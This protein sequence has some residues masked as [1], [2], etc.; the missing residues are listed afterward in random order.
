MLTSVYTPCMAR[1]RLNLSRV[2]LVVSL[3]VNLIGLAALGLLCAKVPAVRENLIPLIRQALLGRSVASSSIEDDVQVHGRQIRLTLSEDKATAMVVLPPPPSDRN[4]LVSLETGTEI[5]LDEDSS[6]S[7][8][9]HDG[10]SLEPNIATSYV[11]DPSGN[12]QLF[13]VL[14][15]QRISEAEGRASCGVTR[16]DGWVVIG[17]CTFEVAGDPNACIVSE[18]QRS[19]GQLT[20]RECE[21]IRG[22]FPELPRQRTAEALSEDGIM[23]SLRAV[24]R[25]MCEAGVIHITRQGGALLS[26]VSPSEALRL[27][28]EGEMGVLCG[29]L[30]TLFLYVALGTGVFDVADIREVDLSRYAPIDGVDTNSHAI[31]EVRAGER[32]FAFD[33]TYN[34]VFRGPSGRL[35]AAED[36]RHF[37]RMDRLDDV[38]V[39]RVWDFCDARGAATELDLTDW[40]PHGYNYW[41]QF[42][43]IVYRTLSIPSTN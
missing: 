11:V 1:R 3:S 24:A 31:L 32:W 43:R 6:L 26:V 18:T 33:S 36:L 14:E 41:S 20:P 39:V 10:G 5:L 2:A 19:L 29:G 34:Y 9:L 7:W 17:R 42:N 27:A 12:R 22:M 16:T 30:R 23:A 35:L 38:E 15:L 21:S 40:D 25:S 4:Y 8:P 37:R 28:A 13:G